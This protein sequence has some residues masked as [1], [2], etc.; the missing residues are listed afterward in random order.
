MQVTFG[1]VA[2]FCLV[3]F[4]ILFAII[5]IV[6]LGG[7][8][9]ALTKLQKTVE[10]LTGKV[11]PVIAKASTTLDTVQRVTVNVGEKADTILTRGETLT[12]NVS[13]KV[14]TTANIVETT[15][16]KPLINISSL[17]AGVSKGVSVYTHAGENG[18]SR[19]SR[20][21]GNGTSDTE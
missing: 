19:R 16:T 20:S 9:I 1:P 13:Q 8:A 12:E 11:E 4:V 17:I 15:V 14:E 5:T 21:N 2:S 18:R 3:F 7:M 10:N 6:A